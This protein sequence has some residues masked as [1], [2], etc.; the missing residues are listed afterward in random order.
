MTLDKMFEGIEWGIDTVLQQQ[1][2]VIES[3]DISYQL[4][5]T[6]LHD[7]VRQK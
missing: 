2:S 1:I 5:S 7:I 4:L 3:L 6:K